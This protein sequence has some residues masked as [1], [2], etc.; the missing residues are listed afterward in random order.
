MVWQL[1]VN[2]SM[3]KQNISGTG[4]KYVLCMVKWYSGYGIGELVHGQ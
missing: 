4:M 2:G 1:V 3:G